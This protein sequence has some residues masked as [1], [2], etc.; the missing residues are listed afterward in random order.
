MRKFFAILLF[1][2]LFAGESLK[3]QYVANISKRGTSMAAFLKIGQGARAVSM[4][5]AFVGVANDAS[6]IYW[7]V[8]GIA[9]LNNN[10]FVFDHTDWVADLKYNFLAGTVSLGNYGTLGVGLTASDYG[11]MKVT[12]VDEPE[13]T[14]EVFSVSDIALSLAWAYNLTDAFTIGFNPKVVYESIW[15]TS[16]YAIGM[17]MGILYNTPF[18]GFTLGMSITNFASKMRLL[19]TSEIVLY[20]PDPSTTG[21]NGRIPAQLYTDYWSLPLV[22]TI[23]VSYKALESYDHKLVF[24]IDAHHPSDNYESVSLGGEYTYRQ[25]FSLRAGYKSLFLKD[26]EESFTLGAGFRQ[27]LLGNVS[28][29]FDYAFLKFGRLNNVHKF[30]LGVDF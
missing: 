21:N 6:A 3:A 9:R 25:I 11:Q 8:A 13:G 20:D 5:S 19:G 24:D 2:S 18:K 16:G 23:G 29:R 27:Q 30:S 28:I 1:I 14:G 7:N 15:K 10:S 22:F 17:D 12:T 26:A 4:G